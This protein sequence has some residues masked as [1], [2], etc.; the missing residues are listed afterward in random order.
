MGKWEPDCRFMLATGIEPTL[1]K[2]SVER[3]SEAYARQVAPGYVMAYSAVKGA[4]GLRRARKANQ[5]KE[6]G[7][8]II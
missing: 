1:S 7:R 4:W 2:M 5:V 6:N 8:L 3:N